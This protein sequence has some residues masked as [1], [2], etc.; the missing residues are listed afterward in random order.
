MTRYPHRS[1]RRQ[2]G[3]SAV[4]LALILPIL[5]A[6]LGAPL[7][8][9]V[10]YWHYTAVQKAAQDAAR[11]LSTVSEI[12]MRQPALALA[13]RTI[14]TEIIDAEL[15]ELGSRSGDAKLTFLCGQ[16]N[17]CDGLGDQA[18]PQTITV[19]IQL[20]F[21]DLIFQKIDTGQFGWT[22]TSIATVRYAG[23]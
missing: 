7:T 10:Y 5:I 17:Q 1:V 9:A 20:T 12:E 8:L 23:K 11:Y 14:A 2:S 21:R 13:A 3:A 6:M 4:E 18:L 19:G 15:A 22:I 16:I